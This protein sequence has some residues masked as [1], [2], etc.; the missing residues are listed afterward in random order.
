MIRNLRCF[1]LAVTATLAFALAPI[2]HAAPI[3]AG[4]TIDLRFSAIAAT[5]SLTALDC[6][7]CVLITSPLDISQTNPTLDI[8]LAAADPPPTAPRPG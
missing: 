6:S 5:G 4:N 3:P 7:A 2:A 8:T 1:A